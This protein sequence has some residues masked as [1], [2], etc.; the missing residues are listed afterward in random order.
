LK[1]ATRCAT[2]KSGKLAAEELATEGREEEEKP[3]NK[4]KK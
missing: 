2:K 3:K 4:N 1:E